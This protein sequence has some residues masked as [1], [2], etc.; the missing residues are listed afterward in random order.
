MIDGE[1]NAV[2]F[3]GSKFGMPKN[4]RGNLT[5]TAMKN[6][7]QLIHKTVSKNKFI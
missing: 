2:L 6:I 5:F 1:G 3:D 4:D 7:E